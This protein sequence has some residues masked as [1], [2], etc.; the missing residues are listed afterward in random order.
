MQSC[1]VICNACGTHTI[2]HRLV[3]QPL[4]LHFLKRCV[5]NEPTHN[6]TPLPFSLLS[7]SLLFPH[8]LSLV[9]SFISFFSEASC[10]KVETLIPRD[11]NARTLPLTNAKQVRVAGNYALNLSLFDLLACVMC[12]NKNNYINIGEQVTGPMRAKWEPKKKRVEVLTLSLLGRS[13]LTLNRLGL[14]LRLLECA[15]QLHE[16]RCNPLILYSRISTLISVQSL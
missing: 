8:H 5:V 12:G 4:V 10:N 9:Y 6:E 14:E 2:W 13:H 3:L 7:H 11:G 15:L 1:Y 16:P